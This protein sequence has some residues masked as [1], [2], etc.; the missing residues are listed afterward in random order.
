VEKY[1]DKVRRDGGVYVVIFSHS[2]FWLAVNL[3][4][5]FI[6]VFF[7]EELENVSLTEVGIS[8]LVYYLSF[9]VFLPVVGFFEDKIEGLKDE[10]FFLIIGYILRGFLLISFAYAGNYWHLYMIQFALGF[11]RAL[12]SPSDKVLFAHL[13]SNKQ[14]ATLWAVDESIINISA[15]I[16]AGIGGYLTHIYNFRIVLFGAGVL[17]ILAGLINFLILNV[18]VKR[19]RTLN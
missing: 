2:L 11:S 15:A 12:A 7:I 13:V 5:P 9:G 18:I 1:S 6:A 14:N 17:T 3:L 19:T 16:G 8:S 10:I 4:S